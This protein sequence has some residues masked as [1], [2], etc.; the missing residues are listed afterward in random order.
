[1][2]GTANL[3]LMAAALAAVGSAAS[4]DDAVVSDC[5]LVAWPPVIQA[6]TGYAS[7]FNLSLTCNEVTVHDIDILMPLLMTFCRT[8][9]G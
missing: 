3:F 8:D 2:R 7:K 4:A 5:T 9:R 6:L 1:M